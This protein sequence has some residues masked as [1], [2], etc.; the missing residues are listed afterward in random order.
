MKRNIPKKAPPI[1]LR[2]LPGFELYSAGMAAIHRGDHDTAAAQLLLMAR[3][4][5]HSAGLEIADHQQETPHHLHFYRLL[6]KQYPDAHFM[7][8]A[9][10]SRLSKFC[11]AVELSSRK[12]RGG[13]PLS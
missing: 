5:L 10:V 13:P 8:N 12:S 2:R 3:T 11:R 1:P 9:Y 4:R 7:Y 6:E